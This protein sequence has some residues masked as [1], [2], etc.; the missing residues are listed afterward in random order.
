MK[1]LP[2][3]DVIAAYISGDG[4]RAL[5]EKHDCA[6]SSIHRLL[7]RNGIKKRGI[8]VY[9]RT[10]FTYKL[11]RIEVVAA[12]NSGSS[13]ASLVMKHHCHASSIHRLLNRNGVETR[14]IG[15]YDRTHLISN[16][17]LSQ[18]QRQ[19]IEGCLLGD[20]CVYD[21][22]GHNANFTVRTIHSS[23]AEHIVNMLPFHFN[24]HT[25]KAHK[26]VICG[27]ETFGKTAYN[28]Q[29]RCDVSLKE[30]R[31]QWYDGRRKIVPDDLSLS[32]T[33]VLYW[34]YGDGATSLVKG[35]TSVILTL[36]TNCF[37][38]NEC[39]MLSGK[40]Y[41]ACGVRFNVNLS[42]GGPVLQVNK[43]QAAWDFFDYIGECTCPC[44]QYKWKSPGPM[45]VNTSWTFI[46]PNGRVHQTSDV[47]KFA[48]EHGLRRSGLYR[49]VSGRRKKYRGWRVPIN[50][51]VN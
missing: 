29:S 48:Q 41:D 4:I 30:F 27:K 47:T 33:A 39:E 46:D 50:R 17:Q 36:C 1:K 38:V 20:G 7:T 8:G 15:V 21:R 24:I 16:S 10:H 22:F 26:T 32:P 43:K 44:F 2:E 28:V 45:Q 3:A 23:F 14:G 35:K 6:I 31:S 13:V 9:D 11:P 40:L 19:V 49:L 51:G 42:K 5:A 12:Y 25:V 18:F 34:F 37:S